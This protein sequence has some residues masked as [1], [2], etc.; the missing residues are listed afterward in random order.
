M[1]SDESD[2]S[3]HRGGAVLRTLRNRMSTDDGLSLVEMLVALVIT[4]IAFTSLAAAILSGVK[5]AQA[6]TTTTAANQLAAEKVET[7]RTIDWSLLGHY[8]DE[9]AWGTGYFQGQ[10]LVEVAAMT[11]SP[12]P[13]E[14]PYFAAQ[15]VNV[16]DVDYS[17]TTRV[18]WSGSSSTSPNDGTTY[19]AKRFSVSISWSVSGVAK[20]VTQSAL[21][22]PNS[23][24]MR[25]PS[26]AVAFTIA[27]TDA[28]VGPDQELGSG[29][30][31]T[32][33]LTLIATTSTAASEVSATYALSTGETA[34]VDLSPDATNK[35]W[36]AICRLEPAHSPP[37]P[38]H[39]TSPPCTRPARRGPC[40][41]TFSSPTRSLHSD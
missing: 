20:T 12:R 37:V 9:S 30:D 4:T 6:S 40:K 25:P 10:S 11:P 41:A 5:A 17:V 23:K 21:R 16:D 38:R 27:V 29:G 35:Y 34:T 28:T 14:V 39:S 22:T 31:F 19:S 18:T 24:E 33:E 26:D 2:I 8:A 32:Q 36:T 7:L 13:A 1:E 3:D 15:T